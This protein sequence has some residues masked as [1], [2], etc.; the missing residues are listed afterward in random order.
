[1]IDTETLL[2][3]LKWRYATKQ[4]A[5]EDRHSELPKVR[6]EKKNIITYLP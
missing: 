2:S 1:M 5:A 4:F 3:Q 6:F